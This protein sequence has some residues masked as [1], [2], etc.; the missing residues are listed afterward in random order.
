MFTEVAP[1]D[2]RNTLKFRLK[3]TWYRLR[4][5]SY[6]TKHN[7]AANFS[8]SLTDSN[9]VLSAFQA[10]TG[11]PRNPAIWRK[12]CEAAVDLPNFSVLVK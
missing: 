11:I 8:R 10:M 1:W 9:P 4:G 6:S 3:G 2:Q 7:L 12:Y 5:L